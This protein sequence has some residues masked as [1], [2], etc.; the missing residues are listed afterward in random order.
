MNFVE[1]L[2]IRE[3]RGFKELFP[4]EEQSQHL[5]APPDF[6]VDNLI[7]GK[8]PARCKA[9]SYSD[10]RFFIY[11]KK[12]YTYIPKN[13]KT[14]VVTLF[15]ETERTDSYYLSDMPQNDTLDV[16]LYNLTD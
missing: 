10:P 3:N 16:K 12:K 1:T 9:V 13:N 11:D 5:I 2:Y 6:V 4:P 8:L 7:V 14:H 15:H